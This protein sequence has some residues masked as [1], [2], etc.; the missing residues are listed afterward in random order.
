MRSRRSA[1]VSLAPVDVD[2]VLPFLTAQAPVMAATIEALRARHGSVGGYLTGP[3]A[4]E[5]AGLPAKT[6]PYRVITDLCVLDFAPDTMRM[7]VRMP[8]RV[9]RRMRMWVRMPMRVRVRVRMR[10]A[11]A[12]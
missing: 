12:C 10:T 3:A 8:M 6:G 5:A 1:A 11:R 7:R 4:R 2:A 9:R